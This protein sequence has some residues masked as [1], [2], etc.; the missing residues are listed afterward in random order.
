MKIEKQ[1]IYPHNGQVKYWKYQLTDTQLRTYSG[2]NP[3]KLRCHEKIFATE[4]EAWNF[5]E[6]AERKKPRIR[7]MKYRSGTWRKIR[8]FVRS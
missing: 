2:K 1:L 8:W 6:K 4:R 3:D 5:A 7:P